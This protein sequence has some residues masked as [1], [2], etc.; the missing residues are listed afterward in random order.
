MN[1]SYEQIRA[2]VSVADTGSF[3][4][5]AKQLNRHRTTLGQ[6]INNLEIETNLIL[7][8][9]SSK[10]PVLTEHGKSLYN[11]AK[12]LS[13]YT[14]SFEQVCL[15]VEKGI[16]SDITIYHSDVVPVALIQ[17]VM[18]AIRKEYRDVNIHWFHK[19]NAETLAGIKNGEV[20]IGLVLINDTNAI[21][22]TD[23]VYLLS[24]PFCLCAAPDAPI[25][26]EPKI[27]LNE[28]KKHRQLVLEDYF[29]AGIEKMVTVSNYYQR[30]ENMNVFLSL[31]TSGDGWAF[32]PRHAVQEMINNNVLKEFRV[33][34]LSATVRFPLAN[35]STYQ[36][37]TGPVRQRLL[38]LLSEFAK[39]Y[40]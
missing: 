29:S 31:L 5:A 16:E 2:F 27:S 23:Y 25:F 19:S 20:D 36:S 10:F 8:D 26:S 17:Q 9:R 24:M 3:S 37:K 33:K 1:I 40:D 34:E 32:V 4:A 12:N 38:E 13:E 22:Q 15:S 18:K 35:W 21:S 14:Q 28:M 11:H 7:F 30:I 6:V 39:Q